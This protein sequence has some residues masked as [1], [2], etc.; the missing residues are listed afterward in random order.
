MKL[1][2]LTFSCIQFWINIRAGLANTQYKIFCRC[3]GGVEPLTFPLGTPVTQLVGSTK[4]SYV[5]LGQYRYWW[6]PL[7][8][9]Y[10][11]RIHRGHL[12]ALSLAIPPW[13]GAMSA[14]DGFGH[15][16]GRN[17]EFCVTEGRLL[18]YCMAYCML[19]QFGLTLT[20][21]RSVN[22]FLLAVRSLVKELSCSKVI[23]IFEKRLFC[24]TYRLASLYLLFTQF[25]WLID[26]DVFIWTPY[27]CFHIMLCLIH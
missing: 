26:F 8:G 18:A 1:A 7:A 6:R 14:G 20:S 4:L 13:V 2:F 22:L 3:N 10:H 9:L 25:L 12:G 24:L 17:G 27:L 19:V 23:V 15:R 5:E 21:W 16:W 11:P